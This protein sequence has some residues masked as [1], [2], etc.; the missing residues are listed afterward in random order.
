MFE[1]Y[2]ELGGSE[3]INSAR[4]IGYINTADCPVGWLQAQ[5][6]AGISDALDEVVEYTVANIDRAPWYDAQDPAT[7]RFFGVHAITMEGLPDSTRTAAVAEG[8]LN[9]GVVGSV[10]HAVRRVRVRAMLSAHGE[11]ALEAG[12]SWLSAALDPD[13][14]GLHG[15]SCGATDACFFAACP[16]VRE[17]ITIATEF[18]VPTALNLFTQP[19]PRSAEMYATENLDV[20]FEEDAEGDY[21]RGTVTGAGAQFFDLTRPL[22][23]V[24]VSSAQAMTFQAAV[25]LGVTAA[26]AVLRLLWL[27]RDGNYI[28][29]GTQDGIPTMSKDW[30]RITV[31]GTPPPGAVSAGILLLLASDQ[32]VGA[33]V[34]VRH[35][36]AE[37]GRSVST[38]FDGDT[39]ESPTARYQWEGPA[40]DSPSLML[41]PE[42]ANILDEE[43]YQDITGGLLRRLHNVTCISGP[44]VEQKLHRGVTYGY[45]VEFVLAAGTPF[46]FGETKTIDY[47][48]YEIELVQ[49]LPLN[50]VEYPSAELA[51]GTA[52][53]STNY[54]LNP[55]GEDSLTGWTFDNGGFTGTDP[56]PFLTFG[57]STEKHEDRAKSFMG[58]LLGSMGAGGV[59][60]GHPDLLFDNYTVL[61]SQPAG[62]RVS[63]TAWVA[64]RIATGDP[65]TT[66]INSIRFEV[67]RQ[68]SGGSNVGSK[69]TVASTSSAAEILAGRPFSLASQLM[70]ATA[71]RVLLRIVC[72]VTW[73]SDTVAADNSDIRLFV[74]S[75]AVTIP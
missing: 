56:S 3:V 20:S 74:D 11:D 49:D 61:G 41:I 44:I 19:T 25:R 64:G 4:A 30:T 32:P 12:F 50:L 62:T 15:N 73:R 34:D 1:G 23:R 17:D 46:I 2:L 71:T 55:S 70:P 54:V 26:A 22:S 18:W 72:N 65:A 53:V 39:T 16:P 14:C 29:A 13:V 7:W 60:A 6:C 38:F 75:V 66:K 69:I 58:R 10:R 42:D 59:K 43:L 63:F 21:A 45:I 37:R 68:T 9:G 47:T 52:V 28:A 27:D 31:T 8:V 24:A 48:S 67:F 51:S 35:V 33:T 40:G 57:L 5:P 36:M